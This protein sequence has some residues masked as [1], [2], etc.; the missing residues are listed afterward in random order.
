MPP[1]SKYL[2]IISLRSVAQEP[3]GDRKCLVIKTQ[4]PRAMFSAIAS[5]KR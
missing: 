3:A 2:A 4:P 5:L 1:D